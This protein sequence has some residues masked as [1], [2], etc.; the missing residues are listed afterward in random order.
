MKPLEELWARIAEAAEE[1]EA[2]ESV[3]LV[4]GP[5]RDR[6]LGRPL[7]EVTDL[8]ITVLGDAP[9]VAS[10]LGWR[11]GGDVVVHERFG[12]ATWSPVDFPVSVDLVTARKEHYPHPGALPV[13]EAGTLEDDLRRRDF[14][15]NAMAKRIWPEPMGQ[16]TDPFGGGED[17]A[18]G[19][20]RILHD[21]SF[22]DDPTRILRLGRMAVRFGF[23]A[24]TGTNRLLHEAIASGVF[25]PVSG[26]RT[27]AE[28][29][30][31]CAEPD[32][33]A[34]VRWFAAA[35]VLGPLGLDAGG[36]R[37][38]RS[39]ERGFR[40]AFKGERE[41]NPRIALALLL[42]GGDTSRAAFSLGLR[43]GAAA[44]LEQLA[45]IG[46]RLGGP[47]TQAS[48]EWSLEAMLKGSTAEERAVLEGSYPGAKNAIRQYENEVAG[49]P[50]LVTGDDLIAAGMRQ[51]PDLGN[52]LRQ[53]REA[54][55]RGTCATRAEAFAMLQLPDIDG[56]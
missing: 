36:D 8:D 5:V 42:T 25:G 49:R 35:G 46:Q 22:V 13:V 40:T 23:R 19:L 9:R 12:T 28:W 2:C 29:E 21:G 32:P 45:G 41:W 50:P 51:G 31:I 38:I 11:W 39:M 10:L 1:S 43:G 14:T 3:H 6:L 18:A 20:L 44:R 54:Q 4:G 56:P 24:D 47:V 27:R 34:A 52:A 16:L 15:I 26:E 33:P 7:E 30:L 48:G 17:L 55:L 53:V 37:G